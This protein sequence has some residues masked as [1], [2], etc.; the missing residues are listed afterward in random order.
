MP[1]LRPKPE[2]PRACLN[3]RREDQ[4]TGL[5]I[6]F[7]A[8]RLPWR[9]IGR[10]SDIEIDSEPLTRKHFCAPPQIGPTMT[11]PNDFLDPVAEPELEPEL[12]HAPDRFFSMATL[13]RNLPF[14]AALAL[15]IF[16]VAYSNFSGHTI[17]GYWE[18]LAIAM[19]LVCIATGWPNAPE[20]KSRFHLVWTQVAHWVAILVAM[21]LVL[22]PGF[23]Q[24]LPVQ[25]AGLVLLLLLGV[26]TFLAGINMM[27][28]RICFLGAAMALSIPAMTWLKQAS[29]LLVLAGVAVVGL[30]IAFWPRGKKASA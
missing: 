19:G 25:A 4:E 3:R 17:N 14:M 22:L 15:A 26:G 29:L 1:A 20:R 24:V 13:L 30:A 12:E 5:A 16:G 18:F 8:P 7:V 6:D 11:D 9:Q 10:Q 21:N 27:S 23:Q 28:L 2:A